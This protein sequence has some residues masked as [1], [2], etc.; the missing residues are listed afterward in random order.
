MFTSAAPQIVKLKIQGGI[1]F[2]SFSCAEKDRKASSL[3]QLNTSFCNFEALKPEDGMQGFDMS[4]AAVQRL[5][6]RTRHIAPSTRRRT[7]QRKE[8]VEVKERIEA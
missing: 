8:Q 4:E 2:G 5:A 3:Q 6:Q 1:K 7:T